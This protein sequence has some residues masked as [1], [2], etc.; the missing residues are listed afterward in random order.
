MDLGPECGDLL[1]PVDNNFFGGATAWV[2]FLTLDKLTVSFDDFVLR[3]RKGLLDLDLK[4]IDGLLPL[5]SEVFHHDS[6]LLNTA[7]GTLTAGIEKWSK[8]FSGSIHSVGV[9]LI[10][11]ELEEWHY[12]FGE[13][14]VRDSFRLTDVGIVPPTIF[15]G[16]VVLV[17]SLPPFNVVN[18]SIVLVILK[19]VPGD[20]I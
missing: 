9:D 20:T 11:V 12:L 19:V 7:L 16:H 18:I 10:L 4:G 17:I 8:V 5:L 1:V 15:N 13:P 14:A 3:P 2:Q 6:S